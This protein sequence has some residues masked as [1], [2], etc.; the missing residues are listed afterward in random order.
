MPVSSGVMSCPS[1]LLADNNPPLRAANVGRKSIVLDNSLHVPPAGMRPGQRAIIGTRM[2]PSIVPPF[3]PDN[4]A[5]EPPLRPLEPLSE[6]KITS[7]FL[8]K[9][10]CL[11][12]SRILPVDQSISSTE[13]PYR[14][15]ALLP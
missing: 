9:P 15:L 5:L 13:S 10:C 4:G 7:V 8:S 6:V 2:P 11:S 3:A 1:I 12:A 14:P